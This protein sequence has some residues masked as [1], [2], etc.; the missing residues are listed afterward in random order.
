MDLSNVNDRGNVEDRRGG[1]SPAAV[2]GGIGAIVI[3]LV[4]GYLGINPQVA[5]QLFQ[6]FG[7][8]GQQQQQAGPGKADGY[9]EFAEKI[10]GT[11]D[12][13]WGEQFPKKFNKQ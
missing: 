10:T 7:G 11:C 5:N 9:K 12:K 2:G 13:I 4:A 6:A 3:T 8:G 1:P